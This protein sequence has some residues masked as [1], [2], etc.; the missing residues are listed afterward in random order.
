MSIGEYFAYLSSKGGMCSIFYGVVTKERAATR[1]V[2][3]FAGGTVMSQ[4]VK[5]TFA[6]KLCL[7]WF[8]V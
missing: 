6:A 7:S 4:N 1:F 2:F 5:L 8:W 3:L